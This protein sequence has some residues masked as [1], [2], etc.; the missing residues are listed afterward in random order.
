MKTSYTTLCRGQVCGV[1]TAYGVTESTVSVEGAEYI[2]YGAFIERDGGQRVEA[3]D[4]Y[5]DPESARELA[6]RL[7]AGAVTPATFPDI[8]SDALYAK[9]FGCR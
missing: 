2:R 8:I 5:A 9:E 4:V 3:R 7:F 1:G 6:R